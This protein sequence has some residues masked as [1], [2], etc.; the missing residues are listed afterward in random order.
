MPTY[1]TDYINMMIEHAK[2]H[3]DTTTAKQPSNITAMDLVA[4]IDVNA[5]V[6]KPK[7]VSTTGQFFQWLW[8]QQYAKGYVATGQMIKPKVV[9]PKL[10]SQEDVI[11]TDFTYQTNVYFKP[12]LF[13]F[14]KLNM[15]RKVDNDHVYSITSLFVD[16]DIPAIVN[17][18]FALRK[19]YETIE[20]YGLPKPQA[21][22]DTG[23][24]IDML[25]R[26]KAGVVGNDNFIAYHQ[27]VL[28]ALARV[29][30][31]GDPQVTSSSNFLRVPGTINNKS[32]K[33]LPAVRGHWI[34]FD[35][36]LPD[37]SLDEVATLLKVAKPHELTATEQASIK[38]KKEAVEFRQNH[39]DYVP[40]K[41]GATKAKS[42]DGIKINYANSDTPAQKSYK[43]YVLTDIKKYILARNE[44]GLNVH[45]YALLMRIRQYGAD[46]KY[47]NNLLAN[48]LYGK[49]LDFLTK[50]EFEGVIMPK[51]A[52]LLDIMEPTAEEMAQMRVIKTREYLVLKDELK[53]IRKKLRPAL[54]KLTK[55]LQREYV[56]RSRGTNS[57]TAKALGIS[58][59]TVK[60]L[61][62]G[63]KVMDNDKLVQLMNL[64]AQLILKDVKAGGT[65]DTDR[66]Q[67][68][69]NT[70]TEIKDASR[71]NQRGL[72]KTIGQLNEI[73]QMIA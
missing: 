10:N 24:G 1:D 2:A 54:T 44:S 5:P 13:K 12:S 33:G 57:N 71:H 37:T 52:D 62:K 21:C 6:A 20:K 26:I 30:L 39:P 17:H 60:R 8:G 65:V 9:T 19:A 42:Y 29:M 43:R 46:V 47:F 28:K 72:L 15:E 67:D 32:Y 70:L 55:Q 66:V 22:W 45:R 16:M 7:K 64:C 49:R 68:L 25:W 14:G 51:V 38:A 23:H 63:E 18:E 4:G 27:A 48:P 3:P 35:P 11:N 53:S 41:K 61:K 40:V 69:I 58:I 56:K 50:H 59:D 73:K 36:E 34:S 31:Y